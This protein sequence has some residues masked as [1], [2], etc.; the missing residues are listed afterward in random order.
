MCDGAKPLR[1]WRMSVSLC[2]PPTH[3]HTHTHTHTLVLDEKARPQRLLPVRSAF[4]LVTLSFLDYFCAI[5]LKF[6]TAKHKTK[7]L[8]FCEK[9][10]LSF[11]LYPPPPPAWR[12]YWQG[13]HDLASTNPDSVAGKEE[14]FV[15]TYLQSVGHKWVFCQRVSLIEVPMAPRLMWQGLVSRC[16]HCHRHC[17]WV[18]RDSRLSAAWL[19]RLCLVL[20]FACG[21]MCLNQTARQNGEKL[22]MHLEHLDTKWS[23]GNQR[24]LIVHA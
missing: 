7:T 18:V 10:F 16:Q 3:T 23:H 6:Y 4:H 9:F 17:A 1:C 14:D 5:S 13:W 2:I 21:E 24:C 12:F 19:Q 22:E 11:C 8:Q 20:P 15:M